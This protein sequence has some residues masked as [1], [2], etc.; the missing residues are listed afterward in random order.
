MVVLQRPTKDWALSSKVWVGS[1]GI[2]TT[3]GGA[4]LKRKVLSPGRLCCSDIKKTALRR[5]KTVLC[6]IYLVLG[7]S[8]G[9]MNYSVGKFMLKKSVRFHCMVRFNSEINICDHPSSISYFLE[10][11]SF[12]VQYFLS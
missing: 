8:I 11:F 4:Y 3:V 10:L 2:A 1:G 6:V 12:C 7:M 5:K 9:Y